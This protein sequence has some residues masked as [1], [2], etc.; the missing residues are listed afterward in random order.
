MIGPFTLVGFFN[1][2][3]G[4]CHNKRIA[5]VGPITLV[6]FF[7]RGIGCALIRDSLHW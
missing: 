3:I 7:N 4:C 6:G 5:M 2:D 1:S